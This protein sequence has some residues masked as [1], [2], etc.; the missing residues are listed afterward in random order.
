[1]G[2]STDVNI[3]RAVEADQSRIIELVTG[4]LSKEFPAD[5]EAYPTG[6][7]KDFSRTYAGPES[8]FFVAEG[9]GKI[10]GTLGVKADGPEAAILRRLF[11]DPDKRKMGVGAKLLDQALEFCRKQNFVE[12][13]IR[14]SSRM[15]SAIRLC[16]S[17]GFEEDGR[18]RLGEV[19][20][21]RFHLRLR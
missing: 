12:V 10:V 18:W 6:D 13:V 14:T 20:L 17:A 8:A 1:M 15:D 16:S 21:I 19:T 11:V 2:I 9:D 3:R 4:I 5:Q 7:L